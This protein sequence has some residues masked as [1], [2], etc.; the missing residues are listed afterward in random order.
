M[1]LP[2]AVLYAVMFVLVVTAELVGFQKWT[3]ASQAYSVV[4]AIQATAAFALFASDPAWRR[5]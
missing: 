4:V 5:K 3:L 2:R 1:R